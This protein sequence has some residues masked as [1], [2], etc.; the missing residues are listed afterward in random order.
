MGLGTEL[1]FRWRLRCEL[2]AHARFRREELRRSG[3]GRWR[4][5]RLVRAAARGEMLS[6]CRT[7]AGLAPSAVA[8]RR[9]GRLPGVAP[10]LWLGLALALLYLPA[11]APRVRASV[12]G[13]LPYGPSNRLWVV[14][15]RTRGGGWLGVSWDQFEQLRRLSA[16]APLAA[17]RYEHVTWDGH[18]G[19]QPI[20]VVAMTRNLPSMLGL[21]TP[22]LLLSPGFWREEYGRNRAVVG[23]AI[24]LDNRA[25]TVA[26]ILPEKAAYWFRPAQ[27]WMPLPARPESGARFLVVA[28]EP[29]RGIAAMPLSAYFLDDLKLARCGWI[30]VL[31]VWVL[32]GFIDVTRLVRRQGWRTLLRGIGYWAYAL[33]AV[34]ILG[35]LML[36]LWDYL[37]TNLPRG[38]LAASMLASLVFLLGYALLGFAG[39]RWCL[40]DQRY[41]CRTCLRRLRM[42]LGQGRLGGILLAAPATEYLCPHGHGKLLV[43]ASPRQPQPRLNWRFAGEWW[44]ELLAA[45][46]TRS[47]ALR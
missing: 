35:V 33:A 37:V 26:G 34:A 16:P 14:S 41:R 19:Q 15:L 11:Q 44:Q 8:W 3:M 10:V 40:E 39:L 17:F 38:E 43:P 22:P 32:L 23:H 1:R 6:D 5:W 27:M 28:E 7:A 45:A 9:L 24:G 30:A 18:Q 46:P 42:P 21:R 29:V 13:R 31:G 2:A 12:L 47:G 20:T 4:A 25:V 36:T